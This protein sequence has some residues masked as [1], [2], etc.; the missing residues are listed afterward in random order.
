MYIG[1]KIIENSQESDSPNGVRIVE[2][3][4]TDGIKETLSK[5]MY[6][7]VISEETCDATTLRDKRIRPVVGHVLA[8]LREW[9]IKIS[10]LQYLSVVLNTS[11]SENEK[12][13]LKKLWK[14]WIPT[15]N[16]VD[17]VDLIT[18]DRVLRDV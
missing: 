16:D 3:T 6:D 9:G 10:E 12:A 4:Y 1:E 2:V 11:L 15:I 17:D 7:A 5:L 8:I 13:A 18:I 14:P